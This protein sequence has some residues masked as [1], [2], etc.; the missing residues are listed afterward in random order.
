[1][2]AELWPWPTGACVT[3]VIN[4]MPLR[5]GLVLLVADSGISVAL[6]ESNPPIHHPSRAAPG[7]GAAA[8]ADAQ[9]ALVV[10]RSDA[11]AVCRDRPG[12]VGCQ[13]PRPGRL[14][15]ARLAATARRTG[16]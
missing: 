9:P 11:G 15:G 6:R 16:R 12:G 7:V 13:R 8:H 14:A 10:A 4:A 3:G 1:M 2:I 5:P